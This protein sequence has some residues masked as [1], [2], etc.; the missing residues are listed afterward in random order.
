MGSESDCD[1]PMVLVRI[2][3]FAS[4]V[5]G[6]WLLISSLGRVEDRESV[7]Q[8]SRQFMGRLLDRVVREERSH[9][10][11]MPRLDLQNIRI[12]GDRASVQVRLSVETGGLDA[13][14]VL[15]RSGRFGRWQVL[16]VSRITD[17]DGTLLIPREHPVPQHEMLDV[18]M[19]RTAFGDA[20]GI[21]V[22]RY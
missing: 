4:V 17:R 15:T 6:A 22:N 12:A 9:D 8:A 20:E 13:D 21:Q 18:E 7:R 11:V 2:I 10:S 16:G 5:L 19:L 3:A 1:L 14:L